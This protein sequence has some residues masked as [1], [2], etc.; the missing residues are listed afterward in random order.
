[1]GI[2]E[3]GLESGIG[4]SAQEHETLDVIKSVLEKMQK[5]PQFAEIE[6]ESLRFISLYGR[7]C[8]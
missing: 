6:A 5:I 2:L 3:A 7:R 4:C 1:M 8:R